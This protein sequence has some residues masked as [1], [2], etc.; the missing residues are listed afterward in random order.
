[1]AKKYI[2]TRTQYRNSGTTAYNNNIPM[3]IAELIEYY[4]YTLEKGASWAHEK[5]NR[6]I[7]KNPKSI[8]SLITNLC[9]SENNAAQNGHA[10][11][12]FTYEEVIVLNK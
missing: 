12:N 7:N 8:K 5:G 2:V 6:K 11:C 4:S 9:N 3:T 10:S 1:M